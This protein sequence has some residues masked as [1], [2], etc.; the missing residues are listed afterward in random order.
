MAALN[1]DC[2]GVVSGR[3]W[4]DPIEPSRTNTALWFYPSIK[5]LLKQKIPCSAASFLFPR[6]FV[7]SL[8]AFDT[9]NLDLRG[10][11]K[12]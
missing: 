7:G 3:K 4:V 10:M 9:N 2:K 8:V 11:F 12:H 5:A 6:S 1:T